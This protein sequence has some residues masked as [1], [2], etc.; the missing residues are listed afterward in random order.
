MLKKFLLRAG[1]FLGAFIPVLLLTAYTAEQRAR[2]AD[3]MYGLKKAYIRHNSEKVKTL[4]LGSSHVYHAVFPE[5]VND[6]TASLACVSQDLRH[7]TKLLKAYLDKLPALENVVLEVSYHS[8]EAMLDALNSRI[9]YYRSHFEEVFPLSFYAHDSVSVFDQVKQS[10]I[11][12]SNYSAL[13]QSISFKK[14]KAAS[15]SE[16]GTMLEIPGTQCYFRKLNYDRSKIMAD[17]STRSYLHRHS[18]EDTAA[19]AVNAQA[20]KEVVQELKERNIRT[21]IFVPPIYRTYLNAMNP[22]RRKRQ[23]ALTNELKQLNPDIKMVDMEN[24]FLDE[25]KM[26][27]NANHVNEEAGIQISKM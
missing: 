23:L 16:Q 22:N 18:G 15:L 21:F 19:F 5:F 14:K 27:M 10:F 11:T 8:P 24:L 12:A 6:S 3:S 17:T 1:A 9:A 2:A 4:F 7:D 26:F 20:L 13:K 25:E